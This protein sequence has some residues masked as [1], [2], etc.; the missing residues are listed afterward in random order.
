MG[1]CCLLDI[2]FQFGK[3]KKCWRW[4]VRIVAQCECILNLTELKMATMI[5]FYVTYI[6]PQFKKTK[7]YLP[8]R[9]WGET[10]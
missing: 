9:I 10:E 7:G 8:Q 2:E 4:V 5:K 3:M 1:S 6:L